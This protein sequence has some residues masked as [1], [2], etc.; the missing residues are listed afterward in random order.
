MKRIS[1]ATWNALTTRA[2]LGTGIA[3]ALLGA[4]GI[5]STAAQAQ[6]IDIVRAAQAAQVEKIAQA[7]TPPAPSAGKPPMVKPPG[8]GSAP[9]ASANPDNMP[10]QRPDAPTNDKMSRQPPASAANA[11]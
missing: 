4:S 5:N 9:G 11:K 1:R 10:I 2:M 8:S 6:T 3:L 7:D